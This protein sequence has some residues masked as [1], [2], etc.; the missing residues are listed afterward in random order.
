MARRLA[1]FLAWA[2]VLAACAAPGAFASDPVPPAGGAAAAESPG[3][4]REGPVVSSLAFRIASP[5]P[6]TYQEL[7]A[8]VTIRPGDRLSDAAVRD[9]IR[10]LYSKSSFREVSAHVRDREDGVELMFYLRPHPAVTEIEV[11]GQRDVT[12][13]QILAASKL[14][15]GAPMDDRSLGEAREGIRKAMRRMGYPEPSVVL[16]AVCNL[17]TGGGKVVIDVREGAR[18]IVRTLEMPGAAHFPKEELLGILGVRIGSRFDH[19]DWEQGVRDLRRAYKEAGFL[20]VHIGELQ[21]TCVEDSGLCLTAPVE[22]GPRYRDSWEGVRAFS[23]SRVREASGILG[24]EETTEGALVYDIRDRLLAFYRERDYFRARVD[25]AVGEGA[26]TEIP[27]VVRVREG[28][29]GYLKEIR[30]VGNAS[31][32]SSRL[33]MQSVSRGRGVF[34]FLTGSGD[35]S[36]DEW[37]DSLNGILGLYQKE[38]FVRARIASVDTDWDEQGR[39]TKTVHIDEGPRY[40][41]RQIRFHGN[42]HFLR[43]ELL[44]LMTNREGAVMNYADMEREQEAVAVHYR[45]AGYLDAQ[46]RNTL[47]F[48]PGTD[49]TV[50]EHVEVREGARYLLGK[51]VVRG[52]LLTSAD[53]VLRELPI[54]EGSPAGEKDLLKFQQSVF[55][56]GLYKSVRIQQVKDAHAGVLD[57]VVEVEETLFFEVEFGGGYGT[58]T[59]IRGFVGARDMNIDGRGRSLSGRILESQREQSY[60]WDLRQPWIF[61]NRWK[62]EGELTGSYLAAERKS[63][64]LRKT[65]LVAGINRKIFDRSSVSLQYELSRDR[66]F[67]VAPGA[68]LSAEDRGG[69]NIAAV[70]GLFALDFRD[71][72]FNPTRGSFNSGSGEVAASFWGSEVNYFR[73]VGQ[74]SWYFPLPWRYT[75]VFSGRAGMVRV[76][77]NTTE[78]PIQK[79]F[80]LGGRTTVRGFK[81]ESLGPVGD[82]GAPTGGNYMV[83]LNSEIR[84]PLQYGFLLAGFLDTGSVW[85]ERSDPGR[86]DL[87]ESAGAGLRYLTPVGP[88]SFDY[89][90]KLDRREGESGSEWHFTIGAIF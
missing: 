29:K 35:Y 14:R 10:G 11:K 74:S 25:V 36:E 54:R 53:V 87:R 58:D 77:R 64:S 70:R 43:Q 12:Q 57:L 1:R 66:V 50:T 80:F 37:S 82:D 40:R 44:P 75:F 3:E 9:S 26:R 22:E 19:R 55:G 89:G 81:E 17:D 15:R 60:V 34:H 33:R 5:Y 8:L 47:A 71:D 65:S 69:A 16:R 41:L 21:V 23:L 28:K 31:I 4:P 90:W 51:T 78:V 62:W 86:F 46:V 13:A 56:T 68:I 67:D 84:I 76:F 49:N 52:N 72:P 39:I 20:T 18:G 24:D 73:L 27:L 42:D 88:I 30:F 83:N 45:N 59:G 38:G 2:F 7:A 6:I 79:R 32:S 48:D 85:F 63:F 61:G